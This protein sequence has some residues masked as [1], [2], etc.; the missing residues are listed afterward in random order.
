MNLAPDTNT[1]K[2]II[3]NA[4]TVAHSLD[5]SEPKVPQYAQKKSKSKMKDTV[6]AKELEEMYERGE[7]K[8]C[9]VGGPFAIDNAVSLEA[10]NIK[11]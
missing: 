3:E 4:C 8:G 7:I 2:Q 5:I 11:V 9:M 1:K 6:E 10:L